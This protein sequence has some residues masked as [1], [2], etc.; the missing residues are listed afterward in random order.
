MVD[1]KLKII[2]VSKNY[3]I[4]EFKH[5]S[6]RIG[7]KYIYSNGEDIKCGDPAEIFSPDDFESAI[8]FLKSAINKGSYFEQFK[9]FIFGPRDED[10][11]NKRINND[12]VR[13]FYVDTVTD[14]KQTVF[15]ELCYLMAELM[16]YI[17]LKEKESNPNYTSLIGK[18]EE[19]KKEIIKL[20][21]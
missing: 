17:L 7:M 8:T 9:S 16:S 10:F 13:V 20:I 18:F 11:E 14:I 15:Y 12:E 6:G 1:K 5:S 19:L 21:T 4:T 2:S 3:K